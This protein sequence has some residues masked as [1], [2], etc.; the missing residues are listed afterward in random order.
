MVLPMGE[1]GLQGT[2]KQQSGNSD[3]F[4]LAH[5]KIPYKE[6]GQNAEGPVVPA[7]NGRIEI[8][9]RLNRI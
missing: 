5:L 6:D 3:L 1:K 8:E 9:E 7:T 2:S 4:S